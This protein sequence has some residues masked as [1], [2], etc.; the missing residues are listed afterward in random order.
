MCT[1]TLKLLSLWP[2]EEVAGPEKQD[3]GGGFGGSDW[4]CHGG[5]IFRL[6]YTNT[7]LKMGP[8]T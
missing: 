5:W 1:F 7:S 2:E 8:C 3:D 6:V 4:A